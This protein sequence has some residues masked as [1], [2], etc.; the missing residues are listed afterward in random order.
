MY[1][2]VSVDWEADTVFH[3]HEGL[4]YML[5]F[6]ARIQHFA[7]G[8]M[9]LSYNFRAQGP[10]RATTRVAEEVLSPLVTEL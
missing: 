8:T 1:R 10:V 3:G 7:R 9:P 5:T 6:S 2:A 4:C